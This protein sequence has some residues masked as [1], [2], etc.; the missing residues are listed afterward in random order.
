MRRLTAILLLCAMAMSYAVAEETDGFDLYLDSCVVATQ[1]DV[2]YRHPNYKYWGQTF[3]KKGCGP[4]SMLNAFSVSFG[5]TDKDMA[6]TLLIELMKIMTDTHQPKKEKINRNRIDRLG[7]DQVYEYPVLGQLKNDFGGVWLSETEDNTV[8]GAEALLMRAL[9]ENEKVTVFSHL[10]LYNGWSDLYDFCLR[11]HEAGYDD[12]IL[13]CSY[14]S[15]GTSGT[16]GPFRSGEDGHFFTPCIRVGS[17]IEQGI[18]YVLDSY[19]MALPG[20]KAIRGVLHGRYAM[21]T[22]KNPFK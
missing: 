8:A 16:G 10:T 5:I 14:T 18:F 21:C 7:S 4:A 13:T 20:E 19:P 1:K 17:F 12:A 6:D 9:E 2:V 3:Y 11:L 15:A 22:E